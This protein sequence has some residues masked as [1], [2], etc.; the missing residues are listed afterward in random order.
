MYEINL[1]DSKFICV[2]KWKETVFIIT[3]NRARQPFCVP[4]S[5]LILLGHGLVLV[6][7]QHCTQKQ[8][9]DDIVLT[10]NVPLHDFSL[11]DKNYL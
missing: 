4:Y 8:R 1:N 3:N 10:L 5:S 9:R 6:Y 2:G 7:I 11:I